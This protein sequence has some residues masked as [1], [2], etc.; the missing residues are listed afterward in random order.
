MV[1]TEE[2]SYSTFNLEWEI[3]G[4]K[5]RL[6]VMGVEWLVLNHKSDMFLQARLTEW[7]EYLPLYGFHDVEEVMRDSLTIDYDSFQKKYDFNW[8][9]SVT[10]TLEYLY[11]L[12]SK[13]YDRF[14]EF[15]E[16]LK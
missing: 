12:K 2:N 5:L 7:M 16:N 13:D 4:D 15:T 1:I 9:L 11:Q 8:W 10:Y 14:F 3:I 6:G